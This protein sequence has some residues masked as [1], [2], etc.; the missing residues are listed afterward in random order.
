LTIAACQDEIE[1]IATVGV[2]DLLQ[3]ALQIGHRPLHAGHLLG[4]DAAD[5][6]WL[7]RLHQLLLRGGREQGPSVGLREGVGG[8]HQLGDLDLPAEAHLPELRQRPARDVAV[9]EQL[10]DL[11]ADAAQQRPLLPAPSP[12]AAI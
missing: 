5:L 11:G 12:P 8:E 4:A 6:L 1:D 7:R 10:D 2:L 3:V 9:L